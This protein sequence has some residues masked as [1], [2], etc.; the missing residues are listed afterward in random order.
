MICLLLYSSCSTSDTQRVSLVTNPII[1]RDWGK[2]PEVFTTS[3]T[4]LCSFVT[5]I[6]HNGQPSHGGNRKSFEVMTTTLPKGTL[7][8]VASL[9]AATLY[10]LLFIAII[11]W[12]LTKIR[13]IFALCRYLCCWTISHWGHYPSSSRCFATDM[14]Y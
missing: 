6:F 7:G 12:L 10:R 14:V 3:G 9:L 13:V 1:S 4:Y 8:S 2:D 5:Q 11:E